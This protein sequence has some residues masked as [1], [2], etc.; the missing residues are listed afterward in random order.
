MPALLQEM[1]EDMLPTPSATLSVEAI[2]KLIYKSDQ[3]D[4]IYSDEKG[5]YVY[6]PNPDITIQKQYEPDQVDREFHEDW[7]SKFSDTTA[8]RSIHKFFYRATPI[9][10]E[11]LIAVDGYRMYIPLPKSAMV[12]V[13]T[14]NQYEFGQLINHFNPYGES[15][16]EYLR[17]AGISV[18]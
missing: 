5:L 17:R 3:N 15:Y 18:V 13:I 2:L 9:G 8:F 11:F 16:D 12:L 7:S 14:K 4:W 6:R 10:R 1:R